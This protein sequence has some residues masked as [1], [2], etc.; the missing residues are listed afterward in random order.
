MI[1]ARMFGG[2][3]KL[4][5]SRSAAA[6][7][8][9]LCCAG[10]MRV[11]ALAQNVVVNVDTV[12]YEGEQ[13]FVLGWACQPGNKSSVDVRIYA[14]APKGAFAVAGRADDESD[15]GVTN[16]CRDREDQQREQCPSIR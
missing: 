11:D 13:A 2:S 4:L 16:A 6:I 12:A 10:V 7:A 9:A 1:A 5:R 14:D 15:P 8:L 3:F